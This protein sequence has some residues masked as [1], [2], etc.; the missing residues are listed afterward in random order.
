MRDGE[1]LGGLDGRGAEDR[2]RLKVEHKGECPEYP[3][4]LVGESS[5]YNFM[6]FLQ[7]GREQMM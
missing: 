1:L 7:M 4:G 5:T 3:V 2:E 6:A